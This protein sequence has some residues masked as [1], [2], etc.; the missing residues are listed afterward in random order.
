[1][2]FDHDSRPPIPP[3][4]GGALDSTELTLIAEDGNRFTSFASRAT[5]PTG[6]GMIVLPDVRGLH[7]YYE[8]LALRF[9]E[10]GIDAVA[11]DYF[12]RTA[13]LGRRGPGF[14]HQPHV[15]QLTFDGLSADVRA[16]A[17][18][19]RS[20][21]GGSVESLFTV[22][23]C[24]GGRLSFLAATLGLD[25]AGAI[26]FY[27]WPIGPHRTGLPAPADVTDRMASPVLA[28]FGGADEG[29]TREAVTSFEAALKASDVESRV[30]TYPDAP[31]SFFDRK[32]DEYSKT[33][34]AA[35]QEVIGF[36]R[37]HT[38]R[39]AARA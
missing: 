36:V 1:M 17:T 21:P 25:L 33:S 20:E 16:A 11:I 26:G 2:C 23:F 37:E 30:I 38:K 4:A 24:V 7:V 32:A 9:A 5:A 14:E 22:G 10:H 34:E 8:D 12:G 29:I 35:W 15:S 18:Y 13:G 6:T 19:L 27:G 31:H 39:S 3:I 28:L